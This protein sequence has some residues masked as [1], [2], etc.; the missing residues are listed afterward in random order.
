MRA[1]KGPLKD[2]VRAFFERNASTDFQIKFV[3]NR[4]GERYEAVKKCVQR[5]ILTPKSNIVRVREGWYRRVRTPEQ[6][7]DVAEA[8]RLGIHGIQIQGKCPDEGVRYY[9]HQNSPF[10]NNNRGHYS[11]EFNGRPV[12]IDVYLRSPTVVVWLKAT[13]NPLDFEEFNQF[14][15]WLLGWAQ[16]KI[17]E[18]TWL[19]KQWGWNMDFV[20][21]S[22][23]KSGYRQMTLQAFRNGWFQIYQKQLDLLRVEVHMTPRDLTLQDIMRIFAEMRSAADGRPRARYQRPPEERGDFSYQ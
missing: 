23:T 3:A 18:P 5:D 9:L 21:M 22:M 15:Y 2:R 20:K 13:K 8:K 16:G 10:K 12:N 19:V 7:A 14:S 6:L 17:P 4:L 11:F 1:K